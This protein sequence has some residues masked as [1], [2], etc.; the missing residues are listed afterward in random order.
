[1]RLRKQNI[2]LTPLTFLIH[3]YNSISASPSTPTP[4]SI[5]NNKRFSRKNTSGIINNGV[6]IKSCKQIDYET[7]DIYGNLRPGIQKMVEYKELPE[8]IW[9]QSEYRKWRWQIIEESLQIKYQRYWIRSRSISLKEIEIHQFCY[10]GGTDND[11]R[12][13]IVFVG[14]RFPGQK[15]FRIQKLK[16][17]L[18]FI[19]RELHNIVSKDYIVVYLH[20]LVNEEENVPPIAWI[21]ECFQIVSNHFLKKLYR[22]FIIHPTFR[23]K[24]WFYILSQKVFWDKILYL[25]SVYKL[26]QFQIDLENVAL[27]GKCWEFCYIFFIVFCI[28]CAFCFLKDM[29]VNYLGKNI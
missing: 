29:N 14:C 27:P 28:L 16:R 17:A 9:K 25:D 20:S 21:H 24:S 13:I 15:L 6:Y 19:I 3:D 22:F 10:I 18:L 4:A 7:Y 12:D 8:K 26:E 23:L 5:L 1:M 2:E 11:G